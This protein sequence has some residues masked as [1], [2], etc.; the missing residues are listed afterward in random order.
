M[1]LQA[2]VS[3]L[4]YSPWNLPSLALYFFAGPLNEAANACLW[5]C[6]DIGELIQLRS[7]R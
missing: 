7:S 6:G 4:A 3:P 1:A 2:I 5:L